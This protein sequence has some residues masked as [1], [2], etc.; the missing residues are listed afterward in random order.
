MFGSAPRAESRFGKLT[1]G[2]AVRSG[3]RQSKSN[4]IL[5][6]MDMVRS[7]GKMASLTHTYLERILARLDVHITPPTRYILRNNSVDNYVDNF[8]TGADGDGV[9]VYASSAARRD[10]SV[11]P[12]PLAPEPVVNGLYK[13]SKWI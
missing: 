12:L 5:F 9:R 4:Q 1:Y 3:S 6:L 10:V 13:V 2:T 8:G 7:Y 11:K